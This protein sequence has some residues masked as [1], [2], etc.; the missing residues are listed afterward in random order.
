LKYALIAFSLF[1]MSAPARAAS[2]Y[3]AASVA[4]PI[5]EQQQIWGP[6]AGSPLPFS[7]SITGAT[8]T[9]SVSGTVEYGVIRGTAS[10]ENL[11]PNFNANAGFVARWLDDVIFSGPSIGFDVLFTIALS[12]SVTG[13]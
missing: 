5:Q 9:S 12:G 13:N 3:A 8:G 6:Q 7:L 1:L 11:L 2:V 10:A 4:I